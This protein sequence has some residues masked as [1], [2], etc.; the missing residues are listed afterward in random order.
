MLTSEVISLSTYVERYTRGH[1]PRRSFF[2]YRAAVH[3]CIF[4][5][6]N[7]SQMMEAKLSRVGFSV[8]HMCNHSSGG[9]VNASRSQ[10][11]EFE[12]PVFIS[13]LLQ[14]MHCPPPAKS[15]LELSDTGLILIVLDGEAVGLQQ[16]KQ[17]HVSSL[18]QVWKGSVRKV[19]NF[20][21]SVKSVKKEL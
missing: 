17:K 20:V 4:D 3:S 21:V 16:K 5:C 10:S 8:A 11:V 14:K 18:S 7:F 13:A 15:S 2:S 9:Y 1:L 19:M 12:G 6:S